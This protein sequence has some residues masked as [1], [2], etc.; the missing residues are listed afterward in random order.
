MEKHGTKH[1]LL[2]SP[3]NPYTKH[4]YQKIVLLELKR[5]ST[6]PIHKVF[7]ENVT[8]SEFETILEELGEHRFSGMPNR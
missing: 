3:N 8:W 7:L 1:A 5:F 4:K 6:P 2:K